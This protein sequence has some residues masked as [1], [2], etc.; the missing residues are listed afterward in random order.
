M[1]ARTLGG[2][3]RR[4]RKSSGYSQ[5]NVA[6]FVG[7]DRAMVSYWETDARRPTDEQMRRLLYLTAR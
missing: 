2:E 4:L 7:V 3:L 1:T 5:E 6:L